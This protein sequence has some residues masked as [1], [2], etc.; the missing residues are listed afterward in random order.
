MQYDMAHLASGVD[1]VTVVFYTSIDYT[2]RKGAFDGWKVWL[3]EMV[4]NEL[5]DER[6]FTWK[7]SEGHD[8][9][10]EVNHTN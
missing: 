4:L 1:D 10:Y 9:E 5:Y 6:R 7:P 3:D 2:F 8:V